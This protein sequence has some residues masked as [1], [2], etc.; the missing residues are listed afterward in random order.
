M[1]ALVRLQQH[2]A[3][4][5]WTTSVSATNIGS[6]KRPGCNWCNGQRV[7]GQQRTVSVHNAA[8]V[9]VVQARGGINGLSGAWQ[10]LKQT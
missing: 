3:G 10:G 2:S 7:Q 8:A 4:Q 9:Q 6:S 5:K 1:F